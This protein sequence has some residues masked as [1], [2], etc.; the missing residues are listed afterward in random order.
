[1]SKTERDLAADGA[2]ALDELFDDAEF[3]EALGAALEEADVDVPAD[4][5]AAD[6]VADVDDAEFDAVDGGEP[7]AIPAATDDEL[8]DELHDEVDAEHDQPDAAAAVDIDD[9][10]TDASTGTVADVTSAEND[11]RF[12]FPEIVPATPD[13]PDGD[14][15]GPAGTAE[16]DDVEPGDAGDGRAE[17]PVAF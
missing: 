15:P 16:H 14:A 8:N 3:D 2:D 1:M 6:D 4:A 13:G 5:E 10:T 12:E 11:D 17:S 9:A 7:D